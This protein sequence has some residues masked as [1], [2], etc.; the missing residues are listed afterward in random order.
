MNNQ[1]IGSIKVPPF[2]RD[3][4]NLWKKKMMLFMKASNPLYIGI[5]LNGPY[6]PVK[7]VVESTT[8][9]GVRIPSSSTPRD[10]YRWRLT[11]S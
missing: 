7:V 5:F 10:P 4:Y 1:R 2:D 6:I 8:A 9:T 3:N 11:R